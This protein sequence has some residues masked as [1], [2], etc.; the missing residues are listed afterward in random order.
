MPAPQRRRRRHTL[1]VS[2]RRSIYEWV[3]I[4]LLL[5]A[6]TV[7][8]V[9][10]GAVKNWS[11]G[12]LMVLV[13]LGA[14]LYV[15]RPFLDREL[16]EWKVPPGGW[17]FL[18]FLLYALIL[19]PF[20]PVAHEARFE[21]LKI[22]S[23]VVAF[24]AWTEWASRYRRW[25]ILLGILLFLG[26]LIVLYAI[27]QHMRGSTMV[28]HMERHEQYGMR[29]SGTFRA[30]A[31]FGAYLG[32][33]LCLAA[34][35]VPM[36][37]AGPLLRLLAGYV[38][39]I[40]LP[41]LFLS[42][43][44]SGWV[45][46]VTGLSVFVLMVVWRRSVR[47][48]LIALVAL[49]LIFG[50]LFGALWATSPMFKQRLHDALAIEGTAGHRILMW[51]DTWDMIRD[52]PLF[53]HGVGNYRW[54]HIPYKTWTEDMW[55]DFAHNDYLHLWADYGLVGFFLMM[56]VFG[57]VVVRCLFLYRRL[58]RER[59]VYLVAGFMGAIAAALGH[60][61]FDF[62]LHIFSLC[63]FL[64]LFGGVTMGGLFAS[65]ALK[66]RKPSLF[67]WMPVAALAGVACLV[68]AVLSLQAGVSG[69]L[70]R[71]GEEKVSRINLH[72]MRL[73]D[74]ARAD[75]T[76]AA[77]IDPSYWLAHLELGDL[78]RREAFWIRDPEY[79]EEKVR[80]ALAHYKRAYAHNPLDMNVVYGIGRSWFMA[81]EEEKSL[82]Y[83]RRTVEYWPS[84]MFYARQLGLQLRQMGRL[85]EALAA[86]EYART[87]DSRDPVVQL[88]IRLIQRD[89]A[90]RQTQ[91]TP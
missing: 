25:R 8:V 45:G 23:Y 16:A 28:L 15:L 41:V 4:L 69:A 10:F 36:R 27:V 42:E 82:D 67:V 68:A 77:R 13:Y 30:P 34:C 1:P 72:T 73:Y 31:L 26:M 5:S 76:R 47:A 74:E 48:F 60:A 7:G 64:I 2:T 53:G 91:D 33:L 80:E 35:I 44:R 57:A 59:D 49:P 65:G 38:F 70:V 62:N 90:R 40:A 46:A 24:W 19:Y 61:M 14:F 11:A 79:R 32:T 54:T 71:V 55:L 29:A 51:E 83:L 17:M 75:F 9:L 87:I 52:R 22:G 78:A 37:V 56:L 6:S 21:I 89:L 86:F 3:A 84:N 58:E 88:N 12:S 18:L 43:S 50:S 81:G 66:A 85:E 39:I 63:H 20:A